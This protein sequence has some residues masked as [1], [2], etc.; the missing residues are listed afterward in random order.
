[1]R[2]VSLSRPR[3]AP[4]PFVHSPLLRAYSWDVFYLQAV[5]LR[6]SVYFD[7]VPSKANI[8]DLPSRRMFDMLSQELAGMRRT[9]PPHDTL[10][11]PSVSEWRAPLR[12]WAHHAAGFGVSFAS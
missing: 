5:A 12:E 6:A 1:M 10:R 2:N 3:S 9:S 7:Y 11:V 8:T 4:P